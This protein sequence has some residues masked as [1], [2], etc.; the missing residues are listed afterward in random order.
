MRT[1]VAAAL[2]FVSTAA[3]AERAKLDVPALI[4]KIMARG[5]GLSMDTAFK[6]SS[7]QDEYAI[8]EAMG[9]KLSGQSL[10]ILKR[11]FDV[12]EAADADSKI[13]KIWFDVSRFFP[14]S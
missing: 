6:V 4:A 13:H 2:F 8:V 12:I 1:I 14:A 10:V 3:T 11:P 9:R 7:V 5:D